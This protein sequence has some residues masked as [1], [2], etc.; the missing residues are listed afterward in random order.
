MSF[1]IDLLK[2]DLTTPGFK[3]PQITMPVGRRLWQ[4][5]ADLIYVTETGLVY[6]VRNGRVT[7]FGS[8]WGIPLVAE[9]FDGL[10]PMSCGLHD[11]GYDGEMEIVIITNAIITFETMVISRKEA[12][13]TF[14]EALSW[15]NNWYKALGQGEA[16]SNFERHGFWEG[17]MLGGRS[18]FRGSV[19]GYEPAGPHYEVN[20]DT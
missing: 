5:C 10:G 2:L 6:I 12:D 19:D 17:V 11:K 3:T 14:Y 20:T 4:H 13:A 7:D 9:K 15:E 18:A 1:E 8:T 16:I